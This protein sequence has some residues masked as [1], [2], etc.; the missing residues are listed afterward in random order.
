MKC[1]VHRIGSFSFWAVIILALAINYGFAA[2][3]KAK[4][5]PSK[6]VAPENEKGAKAGEDETAKY[7]ICSPKY[8]SQQIAA[9]IKFVEGFS[10][11]TTPKLDAILLRADF[12]VN[13]R[14]LDFI[15]ALKSQLEQ[16]KFTNPEDKKL[17]EQEK[18]KELQIH[19][20][21]FEPTI[22]E[23]EVKKLV[24]D[25]FEIRQKSLERLA[26]R[27]KKRVG[28]RE[29]LKDQIVEQKVKELVG[30]TKSSRAGDSLKWD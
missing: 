2:E 23:K 17:F 25:L 29:K 7:A 30:G 6:V 19:V 4:A 26:D 3:P 12:Q 5:G 28:E 8:S 13:C 22:N 9:L 21:I 14:L 20:A 27:L 11:E 15:A 10:P 18:V 24:S 1:R 16:S